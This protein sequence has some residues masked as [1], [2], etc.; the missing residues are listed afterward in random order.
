MDRSSIK[1]SDTP[2]FIYDPSGSSS[3][4]ES[5]PTFSDDGG[6]AHP[7]RDCCIGRHQCTPFDI[8]PVKSDARGHLAKRV[9]HVFIDSWIL[10]DHALVPQVAGFD[11][12]V[13]VHLVED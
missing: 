8:G 12:G 11:H 13:I 3:S 2:S 7:G 9:L 10:R 4:D 1:G 6:W 5:K